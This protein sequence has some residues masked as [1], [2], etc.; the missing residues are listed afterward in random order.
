MFIQYHATDDMFQLFLGVNANA[1]K[2]YIGK[3]DTSDF[4]RSL[5]GQGGLL[6][7]FLTFFD[8]PPRSVW[9]DAKLRGESKVLYILMNSF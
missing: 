4:G 3:G 8:V 2:T 7:A 1:V 5:N 6:G 9:V